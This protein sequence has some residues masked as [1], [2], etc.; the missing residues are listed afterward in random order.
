MKFYIDFNAQ[1]AKEFTSIYSQLHL[2]L[3][4]NENNLA[5]SFPAYMPKN[6]NT[7]GTLGSTIR[8]FS[9]DEAHLK[10]I[11][12]YRDVIKE[13]S[14]ASFTAVLPVP[15]EV[16]CHAIFK[17]SKKLSKSYLRRAVK[18][19]KQFGS[20]ESPECIMK[21]LE[22]LDRKNDHP[23]VNL[24]SRTNKQRYPLHIEVIAKRSPSA[25][26]F[27]SYGLSRQATVPI[28]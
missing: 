6:G 9:H 3:K 2:L 11:N 23:N 14:T 17:R 4:S 13:G 24:I 7:K 27:C 28:F 18:R 10:Q 8:L 15:S 16:I 20:A 25:G 19:S 1:T 5:I 26:K 21:R 22:K 12:V